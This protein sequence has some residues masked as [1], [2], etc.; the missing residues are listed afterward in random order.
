ML[1]LSCTVI[2]PIQVEEIQDIEKVSM[3]AHNFEAEPF[4][5]QTK[6]MLN[7][8]SNKAEFSWSSSDV[9]GI[10]PNEG[11]QVRFPIVDGQVENGTSTKEANFTGGGWA[12]KQASTYMAYYPFLSDMELDKTSI[13]VDYSG[14]VQNGSGSTNHLASFDFM[15]ASAQS[16]T[17]GEISFDFEHLGC[18]FEFEM[19]VPKTGDYTSLIISTD[20]QFAVKGNV[21]I[22]AGTPS[23]VG[24]EWRNEFEVK[25]ENVKVNNEG[26]IVDIFAMIPPVDL[27]SHEITVRLKGPH[28]DFRKK[29]GTGTIFRPGKYY[30]P[31]M[32]NMQG[33][34]V[35]KLED[36]QAFNKAIKTL[37]NGNAEEYALDRYDYNIKHVVFSGGVANEPTLPHVEVSDQTSPNHIWASWDASSNTLYITTSVAKVYANENSS[38]MFRFVENVQSIDFSGFDTSFAT[39]FNQ[40][41]IGCKHLSALGLGGF[42]TSLATDMSRMFKD[43]KSLTSLDLSSFN[44]E[45]VTSLNAMFE[46]CSGLTSINLSSFNTSKVNDY[47]YM[48]NGCSSLTSLDLST[49]STDKYNEDRNW[50]TGLSTPCMFGGCSSLTSID[51]SW[52]TAPITY[53]YDMFGSCTSLTSLKLWDSTKMQGLDTS[54]LDSFSGLFRY[55]SSLKS[56]PDLKYLS[57]TSLVNCGAMFEGCTSLESIDFSNFNTSN[58]TNFGQFLWL[59]SSLKSLDVSNISTFSATDLTR[60][61]ARCSSLTSLNIS[62]FNTE[63]VTGMSEMFEGC[64][65]LKSLDI[66]SFKGSN[67]EDIHLMFCGCASLKTMNLSTFVTPKCL[68]MD[69]LFSGCTKLESVVF[70]ENFDTHAVQDLSSMFSGC[71]TL[72]T[73]DLSDFNTSS[74]RNVGGMFSNCPSLVSVNLSSFDTSHVEDVS[75]IFHWQTALTSLTLG[76]GFKIPSGGHFYVSLADDATVVCDRTQKNQ[77]VKDG[78]FSG[79]S[80]TAHVSWIDRNTGV[81]FAPINATLFQETLNSANGIIVLQDDIVTDQTIVMPS[82]YYQVNLGG[83]TITSTAEIAI[84]SE[85][86]GLT[87]GGYGG[88]VDNSTSTSDNAIAIKHVAGNLDINGGLYITKSN[89]TATVY[90]DYNAE[91]LVIT[92]GTFKNI[93]S[94]TYSKNSEMLPRVLDVHDEGNSIARGNDGRCILCLGGTFFNQNP[95]NGDDVYSCSFLEYGYKSVDNGNGSYTVVKE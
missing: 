86:T 63:L 49:F 79:G 95:A 45:K 25:L 72:T 39:N 90:S 24:S 13:P 14:Q 44:T 30:K 48:F 81:S 9:V 2:E 76:E 15:A 83:H 31:S 60:M 52:M 92:G 5:N 73:V 3:K 88:T 58:V 29:I 89:N 65:S 55:C 28:G 38:D 53:Q 37:A 70:G 33:G 50:V 46:G 20:G 80:M 19:S 10:F 17:Q 61:F 87:I 67:V 27:S 91:R 36:G 18:L 47:G 43:C 16:P 35:I 8:L 41:F 1:A 26:D 51:V 34:E 85:A 23:V 77:M 93:A 74:L 57:T 22:T 66:S 6:T 62:H 32:G 75:D 59:C 94:G 12:V 68:R 69:G 11:T 4:G 21:D 64:S 56:I 7:I 71:S 82:G 54:K 84:Q 78:G 42:D 40:M